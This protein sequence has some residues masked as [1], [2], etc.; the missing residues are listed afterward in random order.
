MKHGWLT[1]VDGS[2]SF[3]WLLGLATDEGEAPI[4]YGE[5]P[6]LWKLVSSFP[7]AVDELG[8]ARTWAN[9]RHYK[10]QLNLDDGQPHLVMEVA[11]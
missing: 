9:E 8:F 1:M 6:N 5:I 2:K 11:K 3:A 7:E 4:F 10:M